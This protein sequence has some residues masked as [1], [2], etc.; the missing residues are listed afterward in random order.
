M[1]SANNDRY[2]CKYDDEVKNYNIEDTKLQDTG[3]VFI[4][5]IKTALGTIIYY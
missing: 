4:T 1:I 3:D 2:R 5:I